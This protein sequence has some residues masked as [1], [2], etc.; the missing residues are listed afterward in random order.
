M[1]EINPGK[2][3]DLDLT[4][5]NAREGR[6]GICGLCGIQGATMPN[7]QAILH[8]SPRR[9]ATRA[10]VISALVLVSSVFLAFVLSGSTAAGSG[11]L[12][13]ANLFAFLALCAFWIAFWSGAVWLI[14]TAGR[15]LP[16]RDW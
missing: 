7:T 11:P 9:G 1:T 8:D 12:E 5:I 3:A 15:R 16:P 10:F 4:Q 14:T 6:S 13:G 2:R